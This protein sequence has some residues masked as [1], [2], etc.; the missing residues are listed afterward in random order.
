MNKKILSIFILSLII[1]S[2]F[3]LFSNKVEAVGMPFGGYVTVIIPCTCN[4]ETGNE[5]VFMSPLY[6]SST[7]IA[8]GGLVYQALGSI[9]YEYFIIP[10]VPT[11]WL[12]GDFIPGAGLCMVGKK[13]Y[14]FPLPSYGRIQSYG[15]SMPGASI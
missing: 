5:W 11:T 10:P 8:G 6:F 4:E 1:F 14:C 13:P 3:F 12:L 9:P 2:S 7:P 15:S